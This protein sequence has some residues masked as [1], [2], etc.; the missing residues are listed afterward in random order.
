MLKTCTCLVT[1]QLKRDQ[2]HL[3]VKVNFQ[4]MNK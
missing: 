3:G 4:V 2:P 1:S